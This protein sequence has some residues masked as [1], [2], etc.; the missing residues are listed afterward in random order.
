MN[1]LLVALL[2]ACSVTPPDEG[3]TVLLY[4]NALSSDSFGAEEE[5]EEALN[6]LVVIVPAPE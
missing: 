6:K 2:V 3:L 4:R 5:G 1:A